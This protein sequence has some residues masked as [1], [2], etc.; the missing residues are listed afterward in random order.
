MTENHGSENSRTPENGPN[1]P[2][3]PM[4]QPVPPPPPPPTV[5]QHVPPPP[6]TGQPVPP[7]PPPYVPPGEQPGPGGVPPTGPLR[8]SIRN[9]ELGVTRP[10]EATLAEKRARLRAEQEQR[11]QELTAQAEAERKAKLRKRLLIGGGVTV[12]VVALVAIWYAASSPSNVTAQCVDNNSVV[13]NDDYCS[14]S[15]YHSHGGYSSGGFI[16]LGGNSYRY[17]YGGTGTIGQKVTG[18]TY[19]APKGANVTTKSGTTVQ[20]GGFGV[21]GGS[22][23]GGTGGSKSGG[24]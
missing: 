2:T 15:Y 10:R 17:N 9:Q 12:G 1:T 4:G 24:S 13:V 3:P 16:Y 22:K 5:G 23:S 19:T 6:P 21:S 20:R 18:G 7:P 11:E 8:G 14:D